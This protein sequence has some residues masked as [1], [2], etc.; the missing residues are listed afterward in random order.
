MDDN[1]LAA[2]SN[3]ERSADQVCDAAQ[4]GACRV[5]TGDYG[6]KRRLAELLATAEQT[7]PKGVREALDMARKCNEANLEL[8]VNFDVPAV[9]RAANGDFQKAI[10]AGQHGMTLAESQG[11][12]QL[13]SRVAGR[14]Q[15]Y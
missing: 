10:E 15:A 11:N 3:Q 4:R 1:G 13:A 7:T 2:S 5:I 6:L 8:P 14:L 12:T 9:A